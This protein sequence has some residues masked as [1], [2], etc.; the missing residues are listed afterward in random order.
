[1]SWEDE[2][3]YRF[4]GQFESQGDQKLLLFQLDEPV[5]TKVEERTICTNTWGGIRNA[6]IRY[7]D[8]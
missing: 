5:V 1:M 3:K 6:G 7:S 4:R 8:I 2:G